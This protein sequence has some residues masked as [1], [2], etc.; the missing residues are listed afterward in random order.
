MR[1]SSLD[2]IKIKQKRG[3]WGLRQSVWG[4]LRG[5]VRS[6]GIVIARAGGQPDAVLLKLLLLN[7][8]SIS[9]FLCLWHFT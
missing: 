6:S 4:V 1:N 3:A 7:L 9:C 2:E 8:K 5:L